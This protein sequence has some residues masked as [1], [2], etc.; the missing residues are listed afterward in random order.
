MEDYPGANQA[1]M[2]LLNTLFKHPYSKIEF[3]TRDLGK[4]RKTAASYLEEL[5]KT[6]LLKKE[7]HGRSSYYIN[8]PLFELFQGYK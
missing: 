7:K 5:T 4:T 8:T 2:D 3:L 1:T 6:G